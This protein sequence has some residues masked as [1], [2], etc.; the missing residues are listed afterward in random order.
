MDWLTKL[1]AQVRIDVPMSGRTSYR[2]G[3]KAD[4]LLIP[5]NLEALQEILDRGHAE[6]IPIRIIGGGTNL[7]V[8]DKGIR[9]IV[10]TLGKGFDD[11]RIISQFKEG[12]AKVYVGAGAQVGELLRQAAAANL[13]GLEFLAGVPGTVGGALVMNSGTKEEFIGDVV[14]SVEVVDGKGKLWLVPGKDINFS[15]R[16]TV[17][18][19]L[20]AIVGVTLQ[21]HK[22]PKKEI[23]EDIRK[24]VRQRK[25]TQPLNQPSAGSVFRNPSGQSVGQLVEEAGLK[26]FQIG[27]AEISKIHGNFIV[28]KGQAKASDIENLIEKIR[29]HVGPDLEMEIHRVGEQDEKV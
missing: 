29:H 20:G 11:F 19:V 22:R 16:K 26:G 4:T 6:Q 21:C 1:K 27:D 7:L 24:R 25:D 9:G 23:L 12:R 10:V 13:G 8:S 5:E 15:Y 2:V 3:G 17:Y 14:S 28:N 18:P